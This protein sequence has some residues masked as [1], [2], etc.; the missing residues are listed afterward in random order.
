MKDILYTGENATETHPW[1]LPGIGYV[2]RTK[3]QAKNTA[4]YVGIKWLLRLNKR[5]IEDGA[6]FHTTIEHYTRTYGREHYGTFR[7]YVWEEKGKKYVEFP[8]NSLMN[9]DVRMTVDEAK[10]F[11]EKMSKTVPPSRSFV[12]KRSKSR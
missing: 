4:M 2:A 8:K 6:Y 11:V 7:G 9:K 3:A 5:E 1:G 12:K 10:H